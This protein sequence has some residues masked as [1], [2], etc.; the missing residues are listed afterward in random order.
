MGY[1]AYRKLGV[2]KGYQYI[3]EME[4][5]FRQ[6]ISFNE[7]QRRMMREGLSFRRADMLDDWRRHSFLRSARTAEGRLT[8]HDWY[9]K[10]IKRLH[11]EAGWSWKEIREFLRDRREPERLTR[12]IRERERL[13]RAYK[14]EGLPE[15]VD[16]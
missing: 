8:L 7:F 4:K 11:D 5:A 15:K 2:I 10:V 12:E 6:G 13:Y 9:D 14:E 1:I 3:Q 16:T